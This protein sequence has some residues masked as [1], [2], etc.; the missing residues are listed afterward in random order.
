VSYFVRRNEGFSSEEETMLKIL[1]SEIDLAERMRCGSGFVQKVSD[2]YSHNSLAFSYK[3]SNR[4][5]LIDAQSHAN[6]RAG[7]R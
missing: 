5:Q 1:S 3:L 4:A 7:I 6:G 2:P